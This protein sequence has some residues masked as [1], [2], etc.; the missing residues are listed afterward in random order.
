MDKLRIL[1]AAAVAAALVSTCAAGSSPVVENA[2]L[3]LQ[4]LVSEIENVLPQS[5]RI[6]ESGIGELPLGWTGPES[7]LYIRVEDTSTRFF[8]T[9][10]FHYYSF[11]RIWLMPPGWE[12]EM[13]HTPYIADSA[14]AF[15]LGLSADHVALYHTAGGNVWDDGPSEFCSALGLDTIRY[16]DLT[17]RV[18]DL[19]IEERLTHT[20]PVATERVRAQH[21]KATLFQMNP[22]R[23][24]GLAGDGPSLY[25]EYVFG[26]EEDPDRSQLA[27]LTEQL[28]GSVFQR[29]NTQVDD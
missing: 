25:L 13:R 8:H 27:N 11:Y 4:G 24:V 7:G 14:P 18:V 9:N 1:I 12:G 2:E 17:R 10:G 20:A 29:F 22:Y 28:A 26:N 21:S 3:E 16:T 6:I 19:E 5:W 15:L 23:I